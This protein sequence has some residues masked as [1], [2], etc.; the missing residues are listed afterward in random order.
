MTDKNKARE[1]LERHQ[2]YPA[3]KKQIMEACAKLSDLNP[4]DRKFVEETLP[5]RLFASAGE[6]ETILGI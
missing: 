1:H 5:N 6:V 4:A 3:T 2:T